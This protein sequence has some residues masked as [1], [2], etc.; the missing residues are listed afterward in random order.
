[1]DTEETIEITPAMIEAGAKVLD[2][3][4]PDGLV[5]TAELRAVEV[6]KAMIARA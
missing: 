1:M 5:G 4:D 2:S 6:F 3:Y